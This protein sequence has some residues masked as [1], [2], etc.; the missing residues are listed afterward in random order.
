MILPVDYEMLDWRERRTVREEYIRLQNN[1]CWYC[2]NDL[3]IDPT[4]EVLNKSLNL[5]LF[6]PKFLDNPIHLQHD[7]ET[8]MTEGAVHAYCNGVL[9]QYEGK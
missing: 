3:S 4:P 5:N 2:D 9:W 7:H 1:K 8:G 6:P